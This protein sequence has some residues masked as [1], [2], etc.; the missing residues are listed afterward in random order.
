MAKTNTRK[1]ILVYAYW[2]EMKEPDV[3]GS[4]YAEKTRGK[5]IFSFEYSHE[6]LKS[7]YAQII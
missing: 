1:E 7:K 2:M 4:L 5:E 3:M 6:W